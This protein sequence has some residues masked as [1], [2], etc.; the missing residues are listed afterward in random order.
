MADI[1][2]YCF[3]GVEKINLGKEKNTADTDKA[4]REKIEE[5]TEK[6]LQKISELQTKLYADAKESVV[7]VLQALDA[8]GKD[9][10]IKHVMSG[11]NPQGIDVFSFKAPN[12]DEASHDFLWRYHLRMPV[13][14]KMAI[15]NRS[16]YEEVLVVKVH[17]L[18]KNYHLPERCIGKD[19]F[20]MKYREIRNFEKHLYENGYRVVKFFL[21]V[22][23]EE[24]RQRFL[25]RITEAEK[26][27][28]F[29]ESDIKERSFW[30]SY[31]SAYEDAVNN[32]STKTAPW[33][34]LPADQKWYTRYLVSEIL[35]K[36]LQ[37]I[38]P[39]YP[40]LSDGIMKN[41]DSYR[42]MLEQENNQ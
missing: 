4:Q 7:I 13:H 42:E 27:W 37:D 14:G 29:S 30:D 25:E 26:N 22:S 12:T 31:I 8:A 11:V 41:L 40:V 15:F 17:D 20:D 34:V 10:T 23:R 5:K 39:A 9:S 1:D 21:N 3:D 35:V 6:N 2:K 16:W 32:T 19:F 18:Y 24:Q 33:Y 38:D 28:K 36:T